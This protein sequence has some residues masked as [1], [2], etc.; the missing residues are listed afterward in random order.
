[1]GSEDIQLSRE[2]AIAWKNRYKDRFP[3]E[4]KLVHVLLDEVFFSYIVSDL[5]YSI[6]WKCIYFMFNMYQFSL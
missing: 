6:H 4:L 5:N 1:M 3:C 2:S